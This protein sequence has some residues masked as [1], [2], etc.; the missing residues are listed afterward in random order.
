M[1][2]N[3]EA[4]IN[5]F[6]NNILTR[7]QNISTLPSGR[8]IIL[9]CVCELFEFVVKVYLSVSFL[10]NGPILMRFSFRADTIEIDLSHNL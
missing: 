1:Y 3:V 4:I 5:A 9:I 2:L 6:V 7:E 8:G 10:S